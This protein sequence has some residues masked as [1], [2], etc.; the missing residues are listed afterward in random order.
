MIWN[1][2]LARVL[3]ALI[4]GALIGIERQWR[5]RMAGLRTNALVATGASL[6]VLLPELAP[7]MHSETGRVAAQVVTGVGFL[8]AGVIMQDGLNV[9][10]LNTAATLWCAAAVGVLAG[11]GLIL[12]ACIG[13]ALV[14]VANVVLRQAATLINRQPQ[15]QVETEQPYHLRIVCQQEDEIRMRGLALEM[16]SGA[17]VVLQALQSRDLKRGRLEIVADLTARPAEA[18]LIEQIV[19]KISLEKSVSSVSWKLALGR[20]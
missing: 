15:A 5:A 20:V 11:L 6:F 16:L 14:I 13:A 12:E 3:L 8:G 7:G 19:S 17:P 1:E 9:R 18:P 10:G 2:F 4:L